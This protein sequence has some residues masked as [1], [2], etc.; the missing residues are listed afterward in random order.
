MRVALILPGLGRVQ[1][2]AETAFLE[3]AR[4]LSRRGVHVE[5][6]GSGTEGTEGLIT[7]VVPC[8]DRRHFE[9]WPS[10]P[11]L[12]TETVY[13]E[14]TF[15]LSLLHSGAYRPERFDFTL[16]CTFPHIAWALRWARRRGRGPRHVFVTQN[17]D[18]PC[19][20]TNAEFRAFHCDGLVCI[21][22]EYY[23]RH[24]HRYPAALIPN[25]VD[26]A[27]F[28]P[29]AVGPCPVDVPADRPVVL[30]V[31]ALTASKRVDQAIT[32]LAGVPE[33]FLLVAGDGPL[34][35]EIARLAEALLP[36]RHR[37]LGSMPRSQMP[38]LYRRAN[39]LLHTSLDEPFGIVYLEGAVSGLPVVAH[40]TPV[41]R[42]ILGNTA[43][44]TDTTNPAALV[45]A[46]RR[47]LGKDGQTLGQLAR[48]RVLADWT[49]DRQ[50]A[51]Y[52][53]FL[54]QL[55]SA[56]RPVRAGA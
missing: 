24:R 16:T 27:P 51:L 37:L 44:L 43:V 15:A 7:H 29:E 23:E 38:A 33:A 26:P 13:E 21:N 30:M 19:R 8:L 50:S 25:G 2:G 48:Q 18:W 28:A 5:L 10:L 9:N 17:G 22:P 32:A 6:F 11:G 54:S 12:R 35:G 41:T 31:S 49:W 36:G 55:Q 1:R 4:G 14:L 20:R 39:A 45:A 53:R 46:L 56:W 52:L 40:D 42:W 3:V 34:R 47:A